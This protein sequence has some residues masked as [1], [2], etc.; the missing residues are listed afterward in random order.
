[1]E[2][3]ATAVPPTNSE[4]EPTL[5]KP[6]ARSVSPWTTSILSMAMPSVSEIIWVYVVC[7]PCPIA[8]VPECSTTRP[9][10]VACRLTFSVCARPPVHSM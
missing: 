6:I 9:C 3:T 8:M 5:P 1:L 10:E 7:S 2:E 4:R